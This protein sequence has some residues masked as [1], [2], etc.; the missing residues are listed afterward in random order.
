VIVPVVF[1]DRF[2]GVYLPALAGWYP[3]LGIDRAS[4]RTD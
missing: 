3:S 2:L 4:L 1:V